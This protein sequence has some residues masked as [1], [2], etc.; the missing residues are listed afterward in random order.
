MKLTLGGS[1]LVVSLICGAA[2]S[3]EA[4]GQVTRTRT[5]PGGHQ[6]TTEWNTTGDGSGTRTR[7]GPGG[8]QTT[9]EWNIQ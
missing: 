9:T 7:T 3:P 5:G 1:I 6:T 2:F 8:H 4:I